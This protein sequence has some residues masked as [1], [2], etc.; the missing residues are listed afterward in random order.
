M[1]YFSYNRWE[2]DDLLYSKTKR[3]DMP[4]KTV[5]ADASGSGFNQL[6]FEKEYYVPDVT[7]YPFFKIRV[8]E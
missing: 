1:K 4:W 2:K 6:V 3:L 7:G 5:P 8:Y